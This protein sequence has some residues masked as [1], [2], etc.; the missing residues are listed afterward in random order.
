M[1]V[2]KAQEIAV[3]LEFDNLCTASHERNRNLQSILDHWGRGDGSKMSNF[4][5][6]RHEWK[7]T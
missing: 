6:I 5:L 1:G 2:K 4:R 7:K 3:N